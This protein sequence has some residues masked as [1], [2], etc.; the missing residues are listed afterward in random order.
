MKNEFDND[1]LLQELKRATQ[2]KSAPKIGE[3]VLIRAS[4]TK[5]PSPIRKLQT[6]RMLVS[7]AGG[8]AVLALVATLA[9]PSVQT[10]GLISAPPTFTPLSFTTADYAAMHSGA[11]EVKTTFEAEFLT[12]EKSQ[13]TI[14][15]LWTYQDLADFKTRMANYFRVDE[16]DVD[17]LESTNFQS[18]RSDAKLLAIGG[19]DKAPGREHIALFE[20]EDFTVPTL[21]PCKVDEITV[22][23]A[24]LEIGSEGPAQIESRA[25]QFLK[26]IAPELSFTDPKVDGSLTNLDGKIPFDEFEV[27][28]HLKLGAQSTP[29]TWRMLWNSRGQLLSLTNASFNHFSPYQQEDG[30]PIK[31]DLLS[32]KVAFDRWNSKNGA[33][34]FEFGV[35]YQPNEYG[36]PRKNIFDVCPN[37]ADVCEVKINRSEKVLGVLRDTSGQTWLVPAYAF[38]ADDVFIGAA[39]ALQD[40]LTPNW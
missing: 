6:P 11:Y 12:T 15:V 30:T 33:A 10:R 16:G 17:S 8:V 38:Y 35:Q 7:L 18:D 13:G 32:A 14:Y 19:K 39:N 21:N 5:S 1:P 24:C 4:E 31:F 29:L 27:V 26:D 25:Q 40:G 23:N 3:D 2:V 34:R 36:Q 28:A 22:W 20:Y 9:Q 37:L